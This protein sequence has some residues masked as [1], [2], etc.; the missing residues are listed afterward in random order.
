MRS[1]NYAGF[2][3]DRIF[4]F[5]RRQGSSPH[6]AQDLTRAR[7]FRAFDRITCLRPGRSREGTLPFV[8]TRHLKHFVAHARAHD[9]TQKRGGGMILGQL[10]TATIAEADARAC[11]LAD[12]EC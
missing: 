4:L 6:D 9:R 2:I 12:L 11:E 10:D 8:S 3:G 7:L 5:L 1:R